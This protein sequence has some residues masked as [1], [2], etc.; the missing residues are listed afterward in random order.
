[1]ILKISVKTPKNQATKC[2]TTQRT[3]LIGHKTNLLRTHVE[4]HNL[5]HLYVQTDDPQD[6]TNR[7]AK[8]EALIKTFYRHLI[9]WLTRANKLAT[10]FDKGITWIRTYI[11]K[12]AHKLY[13][14]GQDLD[15][16]T[17]ITDQELRDLIQIKDL[18]A[19]QQLLINP[20]IT[21]TEEEKKCSDDQ[22]K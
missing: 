21:I 10:K 9:K 16:I 20:L 13:G 1:M 19:M 22:K 5:Y 11:N 2:A 7:C 8:A 18:E 14:K 4:H 12:Q 3:M 15:Q 17:N 6:I